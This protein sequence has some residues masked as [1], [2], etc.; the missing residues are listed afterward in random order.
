[1]SIRAPLLNTGYPIFLSSL[2]IEV[3][4]ADAPSFKA[5]ESFATIVD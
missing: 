3:I 2:N 1:M 4:A 5:L